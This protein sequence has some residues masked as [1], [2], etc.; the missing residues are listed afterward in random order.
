MTYRLAGLPAG[1]AAG[2]R[3]ELIALCAQ[4][5]CGAPWHE[6]PPGA[7][8]TVDRLLGSAA[9]RPDF[10]AVAAFGPDDGL[11]GFAAGWTDTVLSGDG[12][13]FELAELV[14]A[15]AH[16]GLGLGRALHDA[17]L[18]ALPPGPRRLMTLDVP[19]LTGRYAR[20]GW[21]VTERRRPGTT[22]REYVV[23]LRT[24]GAAGAGGADTADGTGGA[25]GADGSKGI[26]ETGGTGGTDRAVGTGRAGLTAPA[27]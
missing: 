6:P 3:D 25:G 4:A 9:A 20:W 12:P 19:E 11:R 26:Y 17:L 1:E 24:D 21:V 5:F 15:P 23:M 8:R 16:Q 27:V 10:L 18:A 13:G 7:V 14:V 2:R 22:D